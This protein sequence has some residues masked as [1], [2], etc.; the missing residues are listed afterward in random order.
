MPSLI[1]SIVKTH[2]A[3]LT[4]HDCIQIAN[5]VDEHLDYLKRKDDSQL[6]FD[7]DSKDWAHFRDW[8]RQLALSKKNTP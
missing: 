4:E 7:F 2:S 8:L 6:S 5:E 3:V 1:Q